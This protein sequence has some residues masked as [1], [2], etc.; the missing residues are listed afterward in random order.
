MTEKNHAA[1]A[2]SGG[3]PLTVRWIGHSCMAVEENGFRILFDPYRDGS[4]PGL[5]N[6]REEADLLLMSHGHADHCASET[7]TIRKGAA[8]PFTITEIHSFHDNENGAKRGANTIRIADDGTYRIAHMGDIGC[9][10]EKEDLEKLAGL[11]VMLVP[12][13]G[14]FTMEPDKVAEL[15]RLL[16]PR[17][18]VPMHFRTET[19]GYDV[20]APLSAYTALA[21][22]VRY[23]GGSVL[24]LPEDL[25]EEG[26]A[27]IVLQPQNG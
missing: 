24:T 9:M 1:A 2:P 5:K 20:I 8:D 26:T 15:V 25:P 11:T 22:D 14:F 7:V 21:G 23:A 12:V 10:P 17:I 16:S 19:F 4:V 3:G 27:T 13:G 6:V 18:V